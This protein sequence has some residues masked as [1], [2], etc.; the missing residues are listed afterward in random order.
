MFSQ[1]VHAQTSS[2][3][4]PSPAAE[5]PAEGPGELPSLTTDRAEYTMTTEAVGAGIL[6][7]ESGLLLESSPSARL[8]HAPAP[9]LRIGLTRRLELRVGGDGMLWQ[10]PGS[11]GTCPRA[12]GLSD[13]GVE[14]KWKLMDEHGYRPALAL[15]PSVSTP[16][17]RSG[18]TSTGYDPT[19][20]LAWAKKLVKGF[21]ASGNFNMSSLTEDQQ[22]FLQHAA[23][24][25]VEHDMPAGW[26]AYW[27]NYNIWPRHRAGER[28]SLWN[29]GLFHGLGKNA[30]ID[31][32]VARCFVS[33]APHWYLGAGLVV[34]CPRSPWW[35]R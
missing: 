28:E 22:R 18:F 7:L 16:V 14:L 19:L 33:A 24:L 8:V 31:L 9:L 34:R 11:D 15:A 10:R 20:K 26:V 5:A 29:T 13:M 6:Q 1:M 27:E 32:E 12:S 21:R 35:R 30:Q 25:C 23:S 3:A 2:D 17:G 4:L